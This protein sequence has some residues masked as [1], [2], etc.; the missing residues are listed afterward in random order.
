MCKWMHVDVYGKMLF[1]FP[2]PLSPCLY[3]LRDGH[4]ETITFLLFVIEDLLIFNLDNTEMCLLLQ[5]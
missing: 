4:S 2:F 3:T 1:I 5:L